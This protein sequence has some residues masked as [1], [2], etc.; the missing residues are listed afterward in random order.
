MLALSLTMLISSILFTH[1]HFEIELVETKDIPPGLVDMKK[2]LEHDVSRGLSE[3]NAAKHNVPGKAIEKLLISKSIQDVIAGALGSEE[4]ENRQR[5]I[6]ERLST[7]GKEPDQILGTVKE[8]SILYPV[9]TKKK[10]KR[11]LGRNGL[12]IKEASQHKLVQPAAPRHP[13]KERH[14]YN[15][16]YSVFAPGVL[17]E[18]RNVISPIIQQ[19]S[20]SDK[21]SG[22]SHS[23]NPVH[24]S[25]K[26]GS[27]PV[28]P[29]QK[30]KISQ[31]TDSQRHQ[32]LSQ[33]IHSSAANGA[34]L[35]HAA[36]KSEHGNEHRFPDVADANKV[37]LAPVLPAD[38]A[39]VFRSRT[40]RILHE[41][42]L[43]SHEYNHREIQSTL[44][45]IPGA[46]ANH[47]PGNT[48]SQPLIKSLR[49]KQLKCRVGP[50]GLECDVPRS[51]EHAAAAVAATPAAPRT[52]KLPIACAIPLLSEGL[53][54]S[55]GPA[56]P[57][58]ALGPPALNLLGGALQDSVD[59]VA[60]LALRPRYAP[61]QPRGAPPPRARHT[62]SGARNLVERILRVQQRLRAYRA[63]AREVA[64]E[65]RAAAA[66]AA[67]ARGIPS[68][69]HS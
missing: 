63:E 13:Q 19:V 23:A 61:L 66:A 1:K 67:A 6:L 24:L 68:Q 8:N 22:D 46:D 28:N 53:G 38:P 7:F 9:D 11:I 18:T 26:L 69:A 49:G 34:Q 40:Q 45:S 41:L 44:H 52:A 62:A 10:D 65:Q 5:N 54:Y 60:S 30:Q 57:R 42:M 16:A 48:A 31:K 59:P 27:L 56:G 32:V 21:L 12:K 58:P 55:C 64:A 39:K 50:A 2:I 3:M 51:V 37:S 29:V 43:K 25:S 20:R 4:N 47:Q 14:H 33:K 17:S 35:G 15:Y 36:D